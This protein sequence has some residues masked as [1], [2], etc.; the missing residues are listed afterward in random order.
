MSYKA[1]IVT[2]TLTGTDFME[3]TCETEAVAQTWVKERAQAWA[4]QVTADGDKLGETSLL[5]G[6]PLWLTT[7]DDGNT[8]NAAI[9]QV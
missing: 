9:K 5:D 4:E 8:F 3:N 2:T 1:V 6:G 7:E